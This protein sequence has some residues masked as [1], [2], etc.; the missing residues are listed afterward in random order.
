MSNKSFLKLMEICSLNNLNQE[1]YK[2][3]KPQLDGASIIKNILFN[4]S[5]CE[6]AVVP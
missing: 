3:K 2:T 1:F 6:V 5:L 4:Y